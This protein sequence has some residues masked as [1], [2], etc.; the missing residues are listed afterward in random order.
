MVLLTEQSSKQIQKSC[1]SKPTKSHTKTDVTL[2]CARV[3][4]GRRSAFWAGF[5]PYRE[6][7]NRH[8]GRPKAN[9]RPVLD[10]F[11]VAVRRNSGPEGRF[12][13]WK[14]YCTTQSALEIIKNTKHT[15]CLVFDCAGQIVCA[16]WPEASENCKGTLSDPRR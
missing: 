10:T 16:V 4:P 6:H 5:W 1:L 3:L 14:H 9:R 8:S 15:F 11:P 12:P 13:G 7:S 2:C